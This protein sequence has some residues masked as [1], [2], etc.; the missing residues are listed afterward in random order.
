MN[1]LTS[2]KP[3]PAMIACVRLWKNKPVHGNDKMVRSIDDKSGNPIRVAFVIDH[4]GV[5]G[6][7]RQLAILLNGLDRARFEP[8]LVTIRKHP[9]SSATSPKAFLFS[10]GKLCSPNAVSQLFK[11][12]RLFRRERIQIVQTYFF[13]ANFMGILAA[14]LARVPVIISSRRDMGF[15]HTTSS[16]AVMRFLN[17]LTDRVLVNSDSV[18]QYV[19]RC[20]GVP[21]EK[22]SVIHNGLDLSL[23]NGK[24]NAAGVKSSLDL[25]PKYPVV[26]IVSNLNR[27]VKRVDVFIDAIP[28]VLKKL[29]ATRFVIVGDGHLRA[30]LEER[31]RSL[32]VTEAVV[33][34]GGVRN[35]DRLLPAFDVGVNGSDSEGFSNAV[36][37]YMAAAIPCVVSDVQGN[38]ELIEDGVEGY[39]FRRGDSNSLAENLTRIL[40]S[41]D[42]ARQM[43]K[44]GR[45]KALREFSA[46]TM[47]RE[48]MEYY[49]ALLAEKTAVQS[50]TRVVKGSRAGADIERF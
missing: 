32:G 6:T 19:A 50:N 38:R 24:A 12:A 21:L 26:G 20:E 45:E 17:R 28:H 36:I 37:E 39:L 7:E 43:G 15:W 23:F 10:T 29:P 46:D 22:I 11:M 25:D 16:R 9:F 18:R 41:P 1:G 44:R 47:V 35:A 42:L 8:Y 34:A 49:E 14:R 13:D 30:G 48:H 31:C 40:Q 2:S 3:N 4:L 5:G 27:Q 33:F